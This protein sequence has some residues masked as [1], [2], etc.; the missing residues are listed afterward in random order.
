MKRILIANG[1][2][3]SLVL[4]SSLKDK[5]QENDNNFFLGYFK[6]ANP[7]KSQ[8]LFT[9]F[10]YLIK[11]SKNLN[12]FDYKSGLQFNFQKLDSDL[13]QADIDEVYIPINSRTKQIYKSFKKHYPAAAFIFY[14]EGLMSYVKV[15]LDIPLR[16][17]MRETQN[18]YIF[19]HEKLKNLLSNSFPAISF[20]TIP[21]ANLLEN[22]TTIQKNLAQLESGAEEGAVASLQSSQ[23]KKYALVLPQYYFENNVRKTNKIIEMYAQNIQKLIADG[24]TIIFKDHPKA[25]LKYSTSLISCFNPKD[26]LLFENIMGG[27]HNQEYSKMLQILPVEVIT[28]KIKIDTV[29]SV[30]STSLFTFPYLF[31]IPA[32]TD[33]AMLDNRR[34]ICSL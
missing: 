3:S 25:K 16:R 21:K 15:L 28:N 30:Y 17:I 23:S 32:K 22:I 4:A 1:S 33:D 19:Y 8:T 31:N 6:N 29:F 12:F 24:Y 26:F 13:E 34:N 9:F 18:Y 14:E 11:T 10:N 5:L 27:E 20:Q 7:E 2:F